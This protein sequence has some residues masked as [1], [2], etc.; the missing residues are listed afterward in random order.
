ML[1]FLL[2]EY[3]NDYAVELFLLYVNREPVVIECQ[4][5]L[6]VLHAGWMETMLSLC[7]DALQTAYLPL[8]LVSL[9]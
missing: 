7:K 8:R 9:S 3:E 5:C 1:L 6:K 2:A 4:R